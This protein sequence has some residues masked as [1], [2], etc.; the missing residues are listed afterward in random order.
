[1]ADQIAL[2]VFPDD[3]GMP[4]ASVA[5]R[6][7]FFFVSDG[8]GRRIARYS[9]FGDLLFLV[10]NDEA[11]A[12]PDG[13]RM[14]TETDG[15]MTRWAFGFPFRSPGRIAV[16]S[17]RHIFVEEIMPDGHHVLDAENQTLQDS[18]VLRF[19]QDGRFMYFIGMGGRGGPPFPRIAGIHHSVNDELVVVSRLATGWKAF[20]HDAQGRQFTVQLRNSAIPA[21]PG[22]Y[23][24]F[25]SI[26][27]VFPAPDARKLFVKI[28]YYRDVFEPLTGNRAGTEALNSY[29]WILD[30]DSEAF[31]GF[32]QV[33]FF[34]HTH[35]ERGREA[36][37]SLQY[38][39]MGVANGG[40]MLFYFPVEDGRAL[41]R[42]NSDGSGARKGRIRIDPEMLVFNS[43]HLSPEGALSALLADEWSATMALWRM[44]EFVAGEPRPWARPLRD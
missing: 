22:L 11:G 27:A 15:Q 13:L 41:L 19:D 28:D 33:P 39:M 9:S 37:V 43:F 21:P 34:E 40:A 42:M 36:R 30:V 3:A 26:D 31:E 16:D 17:R 38:S 4:R 14:R 35:V 5:M 32:A 23:D 25:A 29:V 1:M 10:F 7:G 6:D 44:E 8:A 2:F 24:F 20:W 12:E 18:V